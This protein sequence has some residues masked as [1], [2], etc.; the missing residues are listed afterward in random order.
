ME[1]SYIFKNIRQLKTPIG[2]FAI[3]DREAIPFSVT[4]NLFNLSS[5]V[6]NERGNIIGEIH[7]ETNY[8]IELAA[9]DLEIGQEYHINFSA[10]TWKYCNSGQNTTCLC[11]I[12]DNWAVG[13]GAYDPTDSEKQQQQWAYSRQHGFLEYGNLTEPPAYDESQFSAYTVCETEDSSGFRFRLIDR[14]MEQI[15]FEVAWVKIDKYP[16]IEYES[17]LGF[18]LT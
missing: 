7:T 14:T 1:D 5:Q 12:I 17:A 18:W 11:T 8:T 13:I 3:Y 15:T 10:G 16:T 2:Y 9:K 4:R 6:Y